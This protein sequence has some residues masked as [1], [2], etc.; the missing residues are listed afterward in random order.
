MSCRPLIPVIVLLFQYVYSCTSIIRFMWKD[1]QECEYVAD[2][3]KTI[4][5]PERIAIL[6]FMCDC[7]H[8]TCRVKSIYEKLNLSQPNV[9]RHLGLMKKQ[10]IM[11]RINK[12]GDVYFSL[13]FENRTVRCIQSCLTGFKSTKILKTKL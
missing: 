3:F 5:H 13:N 1:K 6:S 4:S 9:S 11:K 8:Y 10:N 7:K 12:N 2:V